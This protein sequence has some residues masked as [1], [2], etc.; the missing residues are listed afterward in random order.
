M[1]DREADEKQT[2]LEGF[3][4]LHSIT[5]VE[6]GRPQ[7]LSPWKIYRLNAKKN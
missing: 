2:P 4:L 1:I 3:M 6:L 7:T 5:Q